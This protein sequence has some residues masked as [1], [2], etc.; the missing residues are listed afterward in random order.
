MHD[1]S[2]PAA[3]P[4][5]A[6]PLPD[7]SHVLQQMIR[8]LLTTVGQLRST[9]DKQAAHIH[10]LV[11]M[12]FGK[13][14]ER[15]EGPTLFDALPAP[16]AATPPAAPEPEPETT[17]VVKRKG[18]GRRKHSVD[19]PCESARRERSGKGL[20]LLRRATHQDRR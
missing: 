7:D 5:A 20:S 16:E 2:I 11:R 1:A 10:Y 12:T 15:I 3:V 6:V 18:H 8:E 19:L 17:V 13:R 9:I 14:S 4:P